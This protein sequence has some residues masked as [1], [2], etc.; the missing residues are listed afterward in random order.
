MSTFYLIYC[1]KMW[2]MSNINNCLIWPIEKKLINSKDYLFWG[3]RQTS[4]FCSITIQENPMKRLS[5]AEMQLEERLTEFW[6]SE[7]RP[8]PW[9]IGLNE[10]KASPRALAAAKILGREEL[11]AISKFNP[12]RGERDRAI[13]K[14]RQRRLPIWLVAELS[15]YC[16]GTI[17]RILRGKSWHGTQD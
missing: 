2:K 10:G 17:G 13:R 9:P 16:R 11:L 3:N 15:G 12:F 8:L 6:G 7:D 4:I 1:A 5:G 14:L